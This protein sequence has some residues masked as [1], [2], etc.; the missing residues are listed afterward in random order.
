MFLLETNVIV[1]PQYC[2]IGCQFVNSL[3]LHII[4]YLN[5]KILFQTIWQYK[6]YNYPQLAAVKIWLAPIKHTNCHSP[7][8]SILFTIIHTISPCVLREILYKIPLFDECNYLLSLKWRIENTVDLT[9]NK[10]YTPYHCHRLS[11]VFGIYLTNLTNS[12]TWLSWLWMRTS[13][14]EWTVTETCILGTFF[15]N[16]TISSIVRKS[17]THKYEALASV[18][19]RLFII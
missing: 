11:R 1:R 2:P 19:L 8:L 16:R 10:V 13:R 9:Q 17:P 6:Q 12:D 14:I 3:I 7:R 4:L 18:L 5:Q 15:A